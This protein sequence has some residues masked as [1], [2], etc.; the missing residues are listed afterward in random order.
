MKEYL[1]IAQTCERIP[2]LTPG[3]IRHWLFH[4]RDNFR[5]RC[6]SKVGH[7]ILL[8]VA[9]VIRWLDDHKEAA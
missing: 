6:A 9:E 2:G 1:T 4:N 5:S 3:G 7:K 8:D